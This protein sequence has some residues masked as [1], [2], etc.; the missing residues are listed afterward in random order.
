MR[1]RSL[2]VRPFLQTDHYTN[3]HN[4]CKR[5]TASRTKIL[6]GYKWF[7]YGSYAVCLLPDAVFLMNLCLSF[8]CIILDTTLEHNL[9]S[10]KPIA[11]NKIPAKAITYTY[12]MSSDVHSLPVK[13][14]RFALLL[15]IVTLRHVYTDEV[16]LQ[17]L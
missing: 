10:T 9:V 12:T 16:T 15:Y 11:T 2:L 13:S 17:P 3:R 6:L 4:K 8:L 1:K 5:E 7:M 14:V